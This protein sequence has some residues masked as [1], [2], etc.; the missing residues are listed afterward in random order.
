M[1]TTT[2][3]RHT[4]LSS[5]AT[6]IFSCYAVQKLGAQET[7]ARAQQGSIDEIIVTARKRDESIQSVPASINAL[8]A[9]DL[10][11]E[12]I[13][14][15]SDLARSV[16]G[17]T[18]NGA[19]GADEGD[20]RIFIRGLSS[21]TPFPTVGVYFD[22]ASVSNGNVSIGFGGEFEPVVLDL[23]RVEVL[24]GPQ[25]T[26]Y[27]GSAMGGAIKLVSNQ[28]NL[29]NYQFRSGLE[30]ATTDGGEPTYE[31]RETVNIP[32]V[33]DL[34]AFRTSV[35]YR[36]DGGWINR[37]PD[38]LYQVIGQGL[39]PSPNVISQGGANR[40]ETVAARASLLV[41]PT[42]TLSIT[43]SVL[44]QRNQSDAQSIFWPNL[45]H[46]E[47]S[48]VLPEPV[49]DEVLMSIL[50]IA[51]HFDGLDF[52]SI[53]SDYR[54][55]QA[56]IQDYT[57]FFGTIIPAFLPLKSPGNNYSD[58]RSFS[59]ELRIASSDQAARLKYVAGLYFQRERTGVIDLDFI[60]GSGLTTA[61]LPPDIGFYGN[62]SLHTRQL[63]AFGEVTY[64]IYTNLDLTVGGRYFQIRQSHNRLAN[65]AFN[66]GLT[67]DHADSS[68]NGVS[69]KVSLSYNIAANNLIYA[70]AD[71]GFRPGGVN[72]TVPV[73]L[74]AA[75]LAHLGVTNLPPGYDSDSLWNYEIGSKNRFADGK[76]LANV[77]LFYMDWS[78]IQQSVNLP[79]CGFAFNANTGSAVSK[80]GEFEFRVAL[81]GGLKLGT[82]GTYN[83]AVI[84]QAAANTGTQVGNRLLD[85]PKWTFNLNAAY[86][87]QMHDAKAVFARADYQWVGNQVLSLSQTLVTSGGVLPNPGLLQPSYNQLNT[88]IGIESSDWTVR[89]FSVN[90]LNKHPLL[91]YNASPTGQTVAQSLRPRTV[92]V[93]FEYRF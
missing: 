76:I 84:T 39:S 29:E 85:A 57:I 37:V 68:E 26:L 52:T 13:R 23:Q 65:G 19:S 40:A 6:M 42:E 63:A 10:E 30:L 27:G 45:P 64:S 12:E 18:F 43:P 31:A 24:K 91:Q 34:A 79:T 67:T 88:D 38:G 4:V 16:P 51:K 73:D 35:M 21:L 90:L 56:Q 8:S 20:K 28:P 5:I 62:E 60:L 17:L 47:Q 2:V 70:T 14:N 7:S 55:E 92:G 59:Q 77:T 86:R 69:P 71:K 25:G 87:A 36:S 75:D 9:S 32:V 74:C 93:N 22:D 66:G 80:G 49:S 50:T 89:L 83:D 11:A 33:K 58:V 3:L 41:A 82:A 61:G 72:A 53:S 44:Y 46:F 1:N 54:R 81:P 78:K 15:L 48:N